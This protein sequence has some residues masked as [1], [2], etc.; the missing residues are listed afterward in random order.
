VETFGDAVAVYVC[1]DE[2]VE[3]TA[4]TVVDLAH[5]EPRILRHGALA[6]ELVLAAAAD[7]G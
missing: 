2:P 6:E 7:A 5:G 4:S 3:G 1:Q